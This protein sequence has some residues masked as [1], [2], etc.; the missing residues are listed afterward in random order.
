MIEYSE[1]AFEDVDALFG[2]AQ[3]VARAALDGRQAEA[4]PLG[5]DRMKRG[6]AR[7]A[8]NAEHRQVDRRVGF[9]AGVGEQQ[10][11]Q[12]VLALARRRRFD[13]QANGV[14]LA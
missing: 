13:D 14:F 8:G 2:G 11:N 1:P 3:A 6:L 9:Q 7:R 12:V 5:D 10:A 4:A